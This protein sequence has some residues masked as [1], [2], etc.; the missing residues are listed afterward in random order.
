MVD[1]EPA[2]E[3]VCE[4]CGRRDEWDEERD[5][6]TIATDEDG[7]RVVGDPYCLHEWDINGTYNPFTGEK[8][9]HS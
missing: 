2:T 3:R 9:T 8:A 1:I 7:E 4:R 5:A 6:W